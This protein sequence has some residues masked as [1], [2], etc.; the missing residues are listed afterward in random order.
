M[1]SNNIF[2][3]I[4]IMIGL[5][6][7]AVALAYAWLFQMLLRYARNDLSEGAGLFLICFAGL[8]VSVLVLYGGVRLW[9]RPSA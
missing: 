2:G 4:L 9:K 6:G 1:D 3:I 7:S 8:L 5:A